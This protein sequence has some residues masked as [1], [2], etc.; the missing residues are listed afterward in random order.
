MYGIK[1]IPITANEKII[2]NRI[3]KN[4]LI[5]RDKLKETILKG[6]K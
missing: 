3:V 6:S 1:L 2:P 4:I 5:A